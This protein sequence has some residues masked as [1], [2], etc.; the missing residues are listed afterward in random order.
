ML[1]L[2]RR[3][4]LCT[5]GTLAAGGSLAGCLEDSPVVGDTGD[6]GDDRL[7]GD[8]VVDYPGMVDGEASVGADERTIEYEDPSATFELA[9]GYRGDEADGSKLRLGRDLS[10]ETMAAFVAPAYLDAD[11]RFEYHVFADE[12]FVEFADWYVVGISE[13]SLE[14]LGDASFE[15]LRGIA[16]GFVVA[17]EGVDGIGVVDE[18]AD[19]IE[20]SD[21]ADLTGVVINRTSRD[22]RPTAPSVA[23]AF[24]YDADAERLEVVHEGGDSVPAARL[25]FVSV[26]DVTVLEGFEGTVGA[27]DAATLSIAPTAEVEVVWTSEDGA[28]VAMLGEWTGPD[29]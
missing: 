9:A 8:A 13:R 25:S 23:F 19:D 2:Q 21:Q 16:H 17:P 1:S 4:V 26:G 7:R 6:G 27:G 14:G 18:S 3:R 22:H 15:H 12:A 5:L 10:G 28:E 11:E 20:A 29:A 24:Y